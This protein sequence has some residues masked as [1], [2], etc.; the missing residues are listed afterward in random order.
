MKPLKQDG[1]NDKQQSDEFCFCIYDNYICLYNSIIDRHT[2]LSDDKREINMIF[3]EETD[4]RFYIDKSTLPNA[5]YGL[6]A[7][8]K[9]PKDDW[10][11]VIG[12]MV[13]KGGI[14][15]QC[16]H[17]A[18][19]YKFAGSKDNSKIVP[20]GYAGIINHTADTSLQNMELICEQGLSKRSE[21]ASEVIYRTLR[22]IEPGEELLGNYGEDIG[23]E[24]EKIAS[25]ISHH[26]AT[27]SDWET[28][29]GYNLY[30]LKRLTDLL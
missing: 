5:G 1:S 15:D 27:K 17:Y 22:D 23:K 6:F 11:E 26:D 3:V 9:I 29:I 18:K 7:K 10:L 21:H 30:D 14:A 16:T 4:T 12:V 8:V 24:V 25:N 28:F 13:K 2:H 19:R 20:M